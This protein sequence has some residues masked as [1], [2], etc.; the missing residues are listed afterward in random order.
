MFIRVIICLNL[1]QQR[2]TTI[3]ER[4]AQNWACKL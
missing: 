2:G 1:N 4:Q 3:A